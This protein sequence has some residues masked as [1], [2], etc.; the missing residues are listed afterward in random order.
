MK[1]MIIGGPTDANYVDFA[2]DYRQMTGEF[3]K[4]NNSLFLAS[5]APEELKR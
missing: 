1:R 4:R 3:K 5:E 2:P